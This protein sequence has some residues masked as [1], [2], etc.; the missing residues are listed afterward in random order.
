MDD[1]SMKKVF[2]IL[3]QFML[4]TATWSQT[5]KAVYACPMHPEVQKDRP[6]NCPK[7]GM[8]LVKKTVKTTPQKTV[9][10]K[11]EP[12]QVDTGEHKNREEESKTGDL[13]AAEIMGSKVNMQPGK[14][15]VYH[16]YVSDTT[17]NF[18]G[19][20]KHAYAVNGSIPAPTL[21][22]TEGDTAEI[23]LHNNLKKEETLSYKEI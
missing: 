22:F 14:T 4:I 18:T 13:I 16:L 11:E 2:L 7:C 15:V 23:Y 5:N 19:K 17:V 20:N 8:T 6:G 1:K 3:I 9:T 10:Q 12:R 21:V